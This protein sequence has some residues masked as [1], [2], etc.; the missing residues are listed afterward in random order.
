MTAKP[1]HLPRTRHQRFTG[2][3]AMAWMV[4]EAI[5]P[6]SVSQETRAAISDVIML[7]AYNAI[8]VIMPM[9]SMRLKVLTRG[10]MDCI[11]E[12]RPAQKSARNTAPAMAANQ[13]ILRR[14]ASRNVTR[15]ISHTVRTAP[16]PRRTATR[17][18]RLESANALSAGFT[19]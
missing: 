9:A 6:E 12:C 13:M 19:D 16:G 4:P 17:E 8:M 18:P 5:S 7:P 3:V 1:I 15:A 14:T 10:D 11:M 2:L